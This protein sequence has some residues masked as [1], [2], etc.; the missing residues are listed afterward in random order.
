MVVNGEVTT[1]GTTEGSLKVRMGGTF[2]SLRQ[3]MNKG[4][5]PKGDPFQLH[6]PATYT[7]KAHRY[8]IRGFQMWGTDHEPAQTADKDE[9]AECVREALR[10]MQEL[11]LGVQPD[12]EPG[13]RRSRRV[14]TM[15]SVLGPA[16]PNASVRQV[17]MIR[18]TYASS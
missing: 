16:S 14:G 8:G 10:F 17:L 2:G 3:N 7:W 13:G 12:L 11:T 18:S 4:E 5:P 15:K 9:R 1:F 6:A